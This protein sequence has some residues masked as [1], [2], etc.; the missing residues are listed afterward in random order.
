MKAQDVMVSPVITVGENE[1]VRSVAEVLIARR[2][3]AVPVVD[4]TGKLVGIVTEADLMHRAETRTERSYPRWLSLLIGDRAIAAD[5]VRSHAMKVKDLMTQEVRT[6]APGTP[7]YEIA[8]LFEKHHIKRVPI[9]NQGGE[10]VGIVSRANIIQALASARPQLELSLPDASIRDRLL[11]ELKKQQWT[12]VHK[13]NVT[14]KDGV[15]DL[16]ALS[17]PKRNARRSRWRPRR[18][19]AS[20]PSR[21]ISCGNRCL[22]I[23]ATSRNHA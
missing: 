23:K 10:L 11:E 12:H 14:V 3:S 4:S 20:P 13:L 16:W 1:T 18:F 8:E 2:I 5:Y 9:V 17:N 7:L 22:P 6:A 15:V 19:Q 21:T